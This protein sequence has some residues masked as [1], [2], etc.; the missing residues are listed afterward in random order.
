M[1]GSY[2]AAALGLAL[3]C[4]AGCGNSPANGQAA[5]APPAPPSD[6]APGPAALARAYPDHVASVDATHVVLRDGTRLAISD[7]VEGKTSAQRVRRPDLDD[8]FA[9]RY[10]PGRPSGP[11]R[12]G[13]DP[14]RARYEPFFDRVYGDCRR[15]EVT[16]RLRTVRWMPGRGGAPLQ[17][18]SVNGV[19]DRLEAVIR[20]LER[21][22]PAMTRYL[23][24]S[25]GTYNCRVIAGTDQRSMHAYGVAIDINVAQ[26]DY[27]RWSGGEGARYRN[28]IPWEIVEIFE[29]HGFIWGGKWTHFDTMHFEYRPE[30]L[31]PR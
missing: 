12:N 10:V 9:D 22:P 23:V 5:P 29:R 8:M 21:L 16:P 6:A 26:S 11:P 2:S 31:P 13:E 4:G 3:L 25:A 30:L 24:P 14:G 20:D 17:V 1:P 28:R 7:G 19:A 27:W 18:T 15:G